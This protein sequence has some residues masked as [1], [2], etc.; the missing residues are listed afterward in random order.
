[1]TLERKIL[2]WSIMAAIAGPLCLILFWHFTPRTT[3]S[4]SWIDKE[5]KPIEWPYS[6]C[7]SRFPAERKLGDIRVVRID[8]RVYRV[9]QSET[10]DS[11]DG[12]MI[13][14][15]CFPTFSFPRIWKTLELLELPGPVNFERLQSY[16]RGSYLSDGA[17]H[18][19]H[20]HKLPDVS[21]PVNFNQLKTLSGKY[22]TD[23]R[24]LIY[25]QHVVAADIPTFRSI[26]WLFPSPSSTFEP[27]EFASDSKHVYFEGKIVEGANP[28]TFRAL[29]YQDGDH[30][31]PELD[32]SSWRLAFDDRKA[33][34]VGITNLKPL[35]ASSEQLMLL[36]RDADASAVGQKTGEH[37][38]PKKVDDGNL[39]F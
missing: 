10:Y 22:H 28:A 16:Q 29:R 6:D 14:G 7:P 36:R 19:Y 18:Y 24:W 3:C 4:L 12:C 38:A 23:G 2:L 32:F 15:A 33:W 1:M 31:P 5:F 9:Y 37:G 8:Q 26:P 30:F 11:D 25:E 35:A 27:S 17:A 39:L 34:G 21:P 13:G 20:G